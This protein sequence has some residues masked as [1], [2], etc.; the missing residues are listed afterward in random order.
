MAIDSREKRQSA[1]AVGS[2]FSGPSVT[3]NASKDVEWRQQ[4]GYGYSGIELVIMYYQVIGGV[5]TFT[6]GI[7]RKTSKYFMGGLTFVGDI[8]K[9]T[10]KIFVGGLTF[11]GDLAAAFFSQQPIAGALTFV[12]NI[13]TDFIEGVVSAAGVFINIFRRRRR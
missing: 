10:S 11:V 2:Y 13:T 4:V 6:G 5:L 1:V 7:T 12:G 3:P 9:K 8:S